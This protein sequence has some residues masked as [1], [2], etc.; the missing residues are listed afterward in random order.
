MYIERPLWLLFAVINGNVK[1][2]T[3]NVEHVVRGEHALAVSTTIKL[4]DADHHMPD[5]E[6]ILHCG[7]HCTLYFYPTAIAWVG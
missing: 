7:T 4:T 5:S 3:S 1:T 6:S 2:G